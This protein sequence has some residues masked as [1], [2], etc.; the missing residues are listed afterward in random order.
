MFYYFKCLSCEKFIV[1]HAFLSLWDHFQHSSSEHFAFFQTKFQYGLQND[2]L[3]SFSLQILAIRSC[4]SILAMALPSLNSLC[5]YNHLVLVTLLLWLFRLSWISSRFLWYDSAHL[6]ALAIFHFVLYC[7]AIYL[8]VETDMVDIF[9]LK[10][11]QYVW[12]RHEWIDQTS[13]GEFTV[14][15]D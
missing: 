2:F 4:H 12:L 10:L 9:S 13:E 1:R 15:V 3:Y 6:E 7:L 5:E 11:F 14:W 8:F